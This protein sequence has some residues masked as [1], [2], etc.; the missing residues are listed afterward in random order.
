MD[1]ETGVQGIIILYILLVLHGCQTFPYVTSSE[2]SNSPQATEHDHLYMT[3]EK[4]GLEKVK[5]RWPVQDQRAG[6]V[7]DPGR[8]RR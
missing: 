6:N 5:F 3:D 2:L 4:T 8:G 7:S 1:E